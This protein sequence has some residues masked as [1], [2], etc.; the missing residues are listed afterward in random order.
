MDP[1][2]IITTVFALCTAVENLIA[3]GGRF[4]NP[5]RTIA[6]IGHNCDKTLEILQHYQ[7]YLERRCA[8]LEPNERADSIHLENALE[9]S[10]SDLIRDVEKLGQEL[11][12]DGS[13]AETRGDLL[14]NHVQRL[15]SLP[16]LR[17]A[18]ATVKERLKDFEQQQ[19]CL[20]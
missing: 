4:G 8:E 1:L 13:P 18:H 10:C 16:S 14:L 17:Q 3:I 7:R 11:R 6:D 2:S 5:S 20:D 19:S 12:R 15:V 9:R